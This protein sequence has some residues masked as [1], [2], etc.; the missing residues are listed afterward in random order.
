M[1]MSQE[2]SSEF[3]IGL[4]FGSDSVRSLLV[5]VNSG[6]EIASAV[7]FYS[8]WA[9]GKYCEPSKNRFR[10]HPFDY[11]EGIQNTIKGV[12]SQVSDEVVGNIVGI[13]V[14][15]TGSTPVAVDSTGTPLSLLDGFEEN[16]NA[17]FVL[18]KDHTGIKE[19]DEIN[20]LCKKWDIDYS[21]YEGGIYSSEWLLQDSSCF[22]KG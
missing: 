20:R 11:N 22:P 14:D 1:I 13:G 10:Q 3:C 12:V 2:Q 7:H 8:R 4:D 19:A 15:T 17:M 16:P 5:N 6:E 9:D 18:W 21:Q